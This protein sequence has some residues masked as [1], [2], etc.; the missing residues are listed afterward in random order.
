MDRE[1]VKEGMVDKGTVD[2]ERVDTEDMVGMVDAVD[3]LCPLVCIIFS[4][5]RAL[6]YEEKNKNVRR[7][8]SLLGSSPNSWSL[9]QRRR[10]TRK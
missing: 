7:M 9:W 1:T 10:V 3:L 8:S 6:V 5:P 4:S 2:E